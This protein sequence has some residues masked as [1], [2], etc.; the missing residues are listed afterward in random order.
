[1]SS[2]R[3][4]AQHQD[5]CSAGYTIPVSGSF[6]RMQEREDDSGALVEV[7]RYVGACNT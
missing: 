3:L 4:E 7:A 2:R 5:R 1:M 6:R